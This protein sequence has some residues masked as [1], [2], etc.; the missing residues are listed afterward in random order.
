MLCQWLETGNISTEY[1]EVTFVLTNSV[2]YYVSM[3]A[4]TKDGGIFNLAYHHV[5]IR[6]SANSAKLADS[7]T[8]PA[9][10]GGTAPYKVFIIGE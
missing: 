1:F 6:L 10:G 5:C 2:T 3:I 7:T 4:Y 8:K 9:E